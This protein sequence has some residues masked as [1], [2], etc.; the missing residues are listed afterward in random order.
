MYSTS[1]AA[2]AGNVIGSS[3]STPPYFS[4]TELW[5]TEVGT[6]SEPSDRTREFEHAR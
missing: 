1:G 3:P 5:S 2:C 6:T 4:I